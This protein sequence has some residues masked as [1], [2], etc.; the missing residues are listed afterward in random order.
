[1]HKQ[2]KLTLKEKETQKGAA[3]GGCS[4]SWLWKPSSNLSQTPA[5]KAWI[6]I[7]NVNELSHINNVPHLAIWFL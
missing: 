2:I 3:E 4:W 1:M 7:S 5:I 6:S